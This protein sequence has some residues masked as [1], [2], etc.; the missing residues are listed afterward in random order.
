[1]LL[2]EQ[3]E[4]QLETKRKYIVDLGYDP[5]QLGTEIENLQSKCT[6]ELQEMKI[7]MQELT[8]LR[9]KYESLK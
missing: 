5:D 3:T 9:S 8:D 7:R 6:S 4:S 2:V 1:M